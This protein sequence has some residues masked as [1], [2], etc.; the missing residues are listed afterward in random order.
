MNIGYLQKVI[1][2]IYVISKTKV[3]GARLTL[4]NS[5]NKIKYNSPKIKQLIKS[6]LIYGL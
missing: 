6:L 1:T 2:S 4:V 5:Q 3:M